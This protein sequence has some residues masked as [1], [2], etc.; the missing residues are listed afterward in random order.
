M[1]LW[2]LS[3]IIHRQIDIILSSYLIPPWFHRSRNN[4]YLIEV[5]LATS[6]YLRH[7]QTGQHILEVGRAQSHCQP[8]KSGLR[9]RE[10]S[11]GWKP[12]KR[13]E[14]LF[15]WGH[16]VFG[17]GQAL[18]LCVCQMHSY[19]FIY[20][21]VIV[22]LTEMG[23]IPVVWLQDTIRNFK[24]HLYICIEVHFKQIKY[25]LCTI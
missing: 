1:T 20:Q 14:R 3:G 17:K 7:R 15:G 24:G 11:A 19:L 4:R 8:K 2:D 18:L 16:F 23:T 25:V 6:R 10:V 13:K 22:I 9:C 5:T 12:K 21:I